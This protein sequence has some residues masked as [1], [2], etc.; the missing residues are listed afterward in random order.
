MHSRRR[1]LF[2]SVMSKKW[3]HFVITTFIISEMMKPDVRKFGCFFHPEVTSDMYG[4]S[5]TTLKNFIFVVVL[6]PPVCILYLLTMLLL[7]LMEYNWLFFLVM[8]LVIHITVRIVIE[9][10][11]SESGSN[12]NST[13]LSWCCHHFITEWACILWKHRQAMFTCN[14]SIP[15]IQEN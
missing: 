13:V 4:N 8:S 6:G 10:L 15:L 7:P 3:R 11:A 9:T 5:V 14:I 2:G 1:K 12:I